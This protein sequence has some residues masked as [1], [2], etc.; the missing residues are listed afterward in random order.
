[1]PEQRWRAQLARNPTDFVALLALARVLEQKGDVAGA[2]RDRRGDRLAPADRPVLTE[3]AAFHLRAG[4]E[5]QALAILRRVA[6]LHPDA[7][8]T[9][10]PVFTAV[11]ESGRRDDFFAGI[12]REDPEW[13]PSFFGHACQAA[14]SSDGL[15]RVFAIR[16][17]AGKARA[18][19]RRCLIGR[20]QREGRWTN[21]YQAWLNS[22]PPAHRQRVGNVYNGDFELPISNLGFDWILHAQD[23][24]VVDVRPAAG[25]DGRGA[26]KV[27]LL[28]KRWSGPPVLQTLMLFPG[29]IPVRGPGPG[30]SARD[31]A[32][33]PVGPLLPGRRRG[34]ASAAR[35]Q[36]QVPGLVRL[37]RVGRGVRR[38]EGLPGPAPAPGAREPPGRRRHARQC[39][40]QADRNRLVRRL[41][42][43][44]A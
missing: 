35:P 5:P 31:L 17:A 21:A 24:V 9:I 3:A 38:A 41:P 1:M 23:G 12:A 36:R 22:L 30:R 2:R 42:D 19:E 8:A 14:S 29:Q 25:A 27:E 6:D 18:D 43:P 28:N 40:G 4:E 7:R 15:Q 13:W 37:E 44:R 10:W 20:L 39:G 26:L 33:R 32:R 11:L 34:D 16:A